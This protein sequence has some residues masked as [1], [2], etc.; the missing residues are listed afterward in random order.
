[1]SNFIRYSRKKIRTAKLNFEPNFKIGDI[2]I[3]YTKSGFD[4]KEKISLT[5]DKLHKFEEK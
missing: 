3:L 1:M 4:G 2:L 5:N